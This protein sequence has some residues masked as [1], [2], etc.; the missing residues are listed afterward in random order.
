MGIWTVWENDRF[1]PAVRPVQARFVKDSFSWL[2]FLFPPLWLIANRMWVVLLLTA[3]V[4]GGIVTAVAAIDPRA[5]AAVAVALM[6]WFGFEARALKRWALARRGWTLTGVVE[7]TRF[8]NAE[9]RYFSARSSGKSA[10]GANAWTP[11]QAAVPPTP[12]PKTGLQETRPEP[13][14]QNNGLRGDQ[15]ETHKSTQEPERQK[16]DPE[17]G[18]EPTRPEA[19]GQAGGPATTVDAGEGPR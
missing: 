17:A 5:A 12:R 10:A 19:G 6:L 11:P 13:D 4:V 3:L 7:G 15:P 14:L 18:P 1:E 9:R 8:R 16:T 2:A